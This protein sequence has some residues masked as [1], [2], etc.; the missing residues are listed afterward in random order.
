M[1]IALAQSHQTQK[2]QSCTLAKPQNAE[3]SIL[4]T[5]KAVTSKSLCHTQNHAFG[6]VPM[7]RY[8]ALFGAP[9][10]CPQVPKV[11]VLLG[12]SHT[13]SFTLDIH[14]THSTCN[15]VMSL[16]SYMY[17]TKL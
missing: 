13:H 17:F 7:K 10:F 9:D 15:E 4:Y 16:M 12:F 8:S 6:L 5:H 3:T 1:P 11:P 2:H 14:T